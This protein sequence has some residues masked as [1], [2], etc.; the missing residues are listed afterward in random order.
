[1]MRGGRSPTFFSFRGVFPHCSS[2]LGARTLPPCQMRHVR[3]V[4]FSQK[5]FVT[6]PVSPG[7]H[8]DCGVEG[9]DFGS[10]LPK[11]VDSVDPASERHPA[12]QEHPPE[13]PPRA[14]ECHARGTGT[15][16]PWCREKSSVWSTH[17]HLARDNA[18]R[19]AFVVNT[20]LLSKCPDIAV[21]FV[22]DTSRTNAFLFPV[23]SLL[24]RDE[25][26]T[27][28]AVR[29]ASSRTARRLHMSASCR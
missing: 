18:L 29:G 1:M 2:L 25:S 12:R 23:V 27:V 10:G 5:A 4:D 3:H 21:V 13:C 14:D 9:G 19:E 28:N 22:D 16:P 11:G 15:G 20:A 17:I 7:R 24:C 6:F 26:D 8:L